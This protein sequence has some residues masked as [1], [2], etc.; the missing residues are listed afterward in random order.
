MR[1]VGFNSHW[2][3]LNFSILIGMSTEK[4]LFSKQNNIIYWFKCG[5]TEYDDEYIRESARTFEEQYKEHLKAPSPISD[6][7]NTTS[8]TTRVENLKILGRI[9]PGP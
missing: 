7:Q 8:H 1:H 9:W 4:I 5:K 3:G 6:H 2:G